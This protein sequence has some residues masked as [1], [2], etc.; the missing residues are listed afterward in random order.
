MRE[1]R[2]TIAGCS[3][4]RGREGRILTGWAS[5]SERQNALS[6]KGLGK[7][8]REKKKEAQDQHK[9]DARQGGVSHVS[10]RKR[11]W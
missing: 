11:G 9:G 2:K 1:E 3:K 10:R 5:G 7:E 8:A 6:A 4:G